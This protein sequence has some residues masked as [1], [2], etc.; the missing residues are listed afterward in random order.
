MVKSRLKGRLQGGEEVRRGEVPVDLH[1]NFVFPN[2]MREQRQSLGYSKL[3]RLAATIPEISYIRLSKIERGEVVPRPDELRRIAATL[4]I[5]A[6]ELLLDIDAPGFDIAAWAEPFGDG[7]QP[8]IAE[9]RFAVLLAAAVRARRARDASLTIAKI[10]REYGLPPVNLSRVENALKPF[11]RWN[12]ATQRALYALFGVGEQ[13]A[14]RAQVEEQ[15]HSGALDGLLHQIANPHSRHERTRARIVEIAAALEAHAEV[16]AA[17]APSPAPV[18][19]ARMMRVLGAPLTG[20]LIAD[21]PTREEIDAPRSAGD[22]AFA[23]KVCRATLGSGLP[24]Q[25]VV[26]IDPDRFP[27]PGGLAALH[28]EAGWRL[29]SVGTGR[30]GRMLGYSINPELE[31]AL[32]DIDPSRLAA[33][34]SAVYP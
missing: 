8:D 12:A 14:L 24:A 17:P 10:E 9:E 2:R 15:H 22:R 7:G 30:D 25:A 4:N 3:L 16:L 18:A 1:R 21:T 32:D 20:G 5:A 29:L 26:V 13:A 23:L 28:E 11:D 33:V 31:I 34:V 19:S 6:A 27:V